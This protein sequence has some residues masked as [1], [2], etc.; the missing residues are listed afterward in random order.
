MPARG[1]AHRAQDEQ[2]LELC[3]WQR[4]V[5]RLVGERPVGDLGSQGEAA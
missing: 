3:Q 4:L 5:L 1:P 2:S